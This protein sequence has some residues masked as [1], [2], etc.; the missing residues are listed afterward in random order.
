MQ[1]R[2]ALVIPA[3]ACPKLVP[4][5]WNL[6][7]K[8][9]ENGSDNEHECDNVIPLER[10]VVEDCCRDDR[11]YRERNRFLDD[12]ELHQAE[13]ASVDFA[14]DGVCRNHEKV[15]DECYTP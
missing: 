14:A 1:R 11:K 6:L 4:G 7:Q 5:C 3:K 13:W 9:E 2:F 10:F 12:L 15:F 8:R